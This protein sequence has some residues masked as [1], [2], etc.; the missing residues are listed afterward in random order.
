MPVSA[1]R[2][3][4]RKGIRNQRD[5]IIVIDPP[6]KP[7]ST[8]KAFLAATARATY[9]NL[10]PHRRQSGSGGT[11]PLGIYFRENQQPLFQLQRKGRRLISQNAASPTP[12]RL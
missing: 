3:L 8:N 11:R 7:N 2:T 10:S 4:S 1:R 5:R 12:V 9:I 6:V